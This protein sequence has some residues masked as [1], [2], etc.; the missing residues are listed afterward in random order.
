M[1]LSLASSFAQWPK[2]HFPRRP[3][4][5][6]RSVKLLIGCLEL[7]TTSIITHLYAF[8]YFPTTTTTTTICWT[9]MNPVTDASYGKKTVTDWEKKKKSIAT[10]IRRIV[11]FTPTATPSWTNTADSCGFTFDHLAVMTSYIILVYTGRNPSSCEFS[12]I[13]T[14]PPQLIHDSAISICASKFSL[15]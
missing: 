1:L 10:T 6:K 14:E 4:L 7:Q 8:S 13:I 15:E 3:S 12:F 2:R 9:V 5:R 11:H